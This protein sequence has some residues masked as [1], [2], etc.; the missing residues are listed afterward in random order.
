MPCGDALPAEVKALL[1]TLADLGLLTAVTLALCGRSICRPRKSGSAL[2]LLLGN[3]A[4]GSKAGD[5][6]T[7]GSRFSCAIE[8]TTWAAAAASVL[9]LSPVLETGA[10]AVADAAGLSFDSA[11]ADAADGSAACSAILAAGGTAVPGAAAAAALAGIAE[12]ASSS[13]LVLAEPGLL[14]GPL[15]L[16]RLAAC[17]RTRG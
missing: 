11:G 14:A 2:S 13:A 16:P 6:L 12:G 5:R 4:T 7:G 3:L 10:V 1:L 15:F 9:E 17:S 8:E